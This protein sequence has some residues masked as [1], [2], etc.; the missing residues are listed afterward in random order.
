MRTST[1]TMAAGDIQ[2]LR[3]KLKSAEDQ[4]RALELD[5]KSVLER[6]RLDEE[7]I[8]MLERRNRDLEEAKRK[9]GREILDVNRNTEN[10]AQKFSQIKHEIDQ[11]KV[12]END[13]L[14]RQKQDQA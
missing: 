13:L 10:E 11:L 6:K 7:Q 12:K 3:K 2:Q 1:N 14:Q 8:K 9:L 4:V 5:Q